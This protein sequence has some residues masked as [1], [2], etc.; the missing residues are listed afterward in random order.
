MLRRCHLV[1][2]APNKAVEP[3]PSSVR[4]APAS[5]RGSPPALIKAN[6]LTLKLG[7]YYQSHSEAS[8]EILVT[9]ASNLTAHSLALTHVLGL[10][11]G[12]LLAG[13]QTAEVLRMLKGTDEEADLRTALQRPNVRREDAADLF[14]KHLNMYFDV[15][16]KL[17]LAREMKAN[18][19]SDA[20]INRAT[21][22]DRPNLF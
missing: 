19:F 22:A 16:S 6:E 1:H 5:G 20:M 21:S 18:G 2:P 14:M 3:T 13:Q 4:C 15:G 12:A 17:L 11:K 7:R 9:V 8:N 10:R